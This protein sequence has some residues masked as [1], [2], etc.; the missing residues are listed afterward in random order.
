M[1]PLFGNLNLLRHVLDAYPKSRLGEVAASK[2][3]IDAVADTAYQW[4]NGGDAA[5]ASALLEP[6]FSGSEP[7]TVRVA[8]LFNL[9]MDSWLELGRSTKRERLI[10][11]ILQRGD[12]PLKSD[13]LQRRTTMLADRGDYAGAWRTFKQASELNPNDPALSFLEVTTLLSE[14]AGE[15]GPVTSPMVGGL[16]GQ[17]ARPA[18]GRPGGSFAR[19]RQRPPCRHD[20]RCHIGQCRPAA[21]ACPVP[22]SPAPCGATPI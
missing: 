19:H 17:A 4:L 9:L 10:D 18:T 11:T 20:G 2:A 5:R 7:L 12:R 6:Y 15:R 8:P 3:S 14:G 1:P 13:A 16:S 21:A 22:G